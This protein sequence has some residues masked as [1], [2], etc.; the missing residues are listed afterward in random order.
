[1]CFHID[2]VENIVQYILTDSTYENHPDY[3]MLNFG[4]NPNQ[5]LI[6]CEG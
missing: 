4:N 1:M 6:S 5:T 2:V 3:T